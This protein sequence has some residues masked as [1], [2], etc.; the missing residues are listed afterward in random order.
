MKFIGRRL[1]IERLQAL[2]KKQASTISVVYGRRRVGKS[3][4]VRQAFINEPI[5][6]FEGL[7][8]QRKAKQ[9][10]N[11]YSQLRQ[12]GYRVDTGSTPKEWRTALLSLLPILKQHKAVVL[13]LDE[14]Q[15][16]ANYRNELV[17]DLKMVWDQYYSRLNTKVTLILCGSIA[18][19]MIKKVI[20]SKALFGRTTTNIHL[21]PFSPRESKQMLCHIGNEEALEAHL[22]LGGIPLYLE[23]LEGKP[24]IRLAIQEICFTKYGDLIDEFDKIFISHFGQNEDFIKIVKTLANSTYG[25]SRQEI[26]KNARVD[27]GGGLTRQLYDLEKAGFIDSFTPF[28]KA[29]SKRK[30]KYCLTDSFLRFYLK[31]MLP[32]RGK[33]KS[34]QSDIFLKIA[35]SPS[36]W[37]WLGQS[38]EIV[39]LHYS[40]IIADKLGFS[41]VD[42]NVGPYFQIKNGSLQGVQVDLLFDRA[43]QVITLCE[44]K[45]QDAKI[46][47]EIIEDVQ[48]KVQSLPVSQNRTV[49]KVLISRSAPTEDLKNSGYFFKILNIYELFF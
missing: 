10:E 37:S 17:S 21:P 44:I 29:S 7:E 26:S 16:M 46:G 25:L 23:K 12:Q 34:N 2:L 38:L 43:D 30:V 45:Y 24:S 27:L 48:K 28:N 36:F 39:C 1:E 41:A 13:F 22:I 9:I 31:F 33:V 15:W 42:Y 49:Q 11:F 35:Q 5:L 20:N 18:S 4:L 3:S 19:F 32:N 14:F 8:N 47:K 6:E 40:S